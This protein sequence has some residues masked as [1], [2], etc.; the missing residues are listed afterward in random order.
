MENL[1]AFPETLPDNWVKVRDSVILPWIFDSSL[2]SGRP[3][4]WRKR[5]EDWQNSQKK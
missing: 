2:G 4:R 1:L 3:S 5:L